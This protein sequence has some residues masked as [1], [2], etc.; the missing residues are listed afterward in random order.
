MSNG[1][2][3]QPPTLSIL[4]GKTS[5]QIAGAVAALS[6]TETFAGADR[7]ERIARIDPDL[8][9][10]ALVDRRELPLGFAMPF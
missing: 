6:R 8:F 1:N 3:T 5:L 4:E 7:I 10:H 2:S 9:E